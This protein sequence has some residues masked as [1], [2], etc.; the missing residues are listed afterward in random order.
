MPGPILIGGDFNTNDEV[1]QFIPNYNNVNFLYFSG[2][3][4]GFAPSMAVQGADSSVGMGFD[5][6]G[7]NSF[8]FTSHTFGNSEFRIMETGLPITSLSVAE[9]V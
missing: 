6:Q 5:V 3:P 4:P 1:A 9:A 2:G 8:S 7:D